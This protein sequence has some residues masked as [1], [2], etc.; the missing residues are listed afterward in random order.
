[1]ISC[2]WEGSVLVTSL[3]FS[4]YLS[5]DSAH[6]IKPKTLDGQFTSFDKRIN[7]KLNFASSKLVLVCHICSEIFVSKSRK[8]VE[9]TDIF[10]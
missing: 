1:M 9:G 5:F 8:A 4:L 2:C 10:P 6:E 3:V 7:S